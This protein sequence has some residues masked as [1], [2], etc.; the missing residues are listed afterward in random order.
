MS[1]PLSGAERDS[2]Y[3]SQA[4][5]DATTAHLNKNLWQAALAAKEAE[6]KHSSC[7]AIREAPLPPPKV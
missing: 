4:D 3:P 7:K 5:A 6:I 1:R 2:T